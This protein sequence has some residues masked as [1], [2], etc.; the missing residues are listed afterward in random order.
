MQ[1]TNNAFMTFQS[2]RYKWL[3]FCYNCINYSRMYF[4]IFAFIAQCKVTQR[5]EIII[6]REIVV[7]NQKFSNTLI[8][9]GEIFIELFFGVTARLRAIHEIY[10]LD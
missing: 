1:F 10:I 2:A 9:T 4:S 8:F 7:V 5:F 3:N 6:Q